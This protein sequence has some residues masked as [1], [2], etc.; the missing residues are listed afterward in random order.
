MDAPGFE[1]GTFYLQADALTTELYVP[2]V[3]FT[4]PARDVLAWVSMLYLARGYIP[5]SLGLMQ[6]VFFSNGQ[7]IIKIFY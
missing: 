7:I 6:F 5:H 2:P 3:G 1:P 4:I